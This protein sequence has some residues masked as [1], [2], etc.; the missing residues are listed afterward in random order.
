M[1]PQPEAV[2]PVVKENAHI[3]FS[4]YPV[5]VPETVAQP[6]GKAPVPE[7]E[8]GSPVGGACV[9]VNQGQLT[10]KI[11]DQ[12]FDI[13]PVAQKPQG[14]VGGNPAAANGGAGAQAVAPLLGG[15]LPLVVDQIPQAK[16]STGCSAIYLSRI[17]AAS[18]TIRAQGRLA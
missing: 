6:D 14:V 3:A 17:S 2:A 11:S 7:A 5:I 18:L 9:A 15:N 12:L 4:G 10:L 16:S 1:R 8:V 13:R